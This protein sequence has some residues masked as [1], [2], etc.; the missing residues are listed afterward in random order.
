VQGHLQVDVNGTYR[1]S[2]KDRNQLP[3]LSPRVA[4]AL[5]SDFDEVREYIR[6]NNL[7]LPE[8]T[9]DDGV[10]RRT[11]RHGFAVRGPQS[12]PTRQATAPSS[13]NYGEPSA[14]A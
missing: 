6:G 8:V 7:V 4:Y 13:I 1:A 12:F 10:S 9:G 11:L 14:A 2:R 5:R 3:G